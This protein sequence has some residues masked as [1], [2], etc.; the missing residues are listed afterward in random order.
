MTLPYLTTAFN[1]RE[2]DRIDTLRRAWFDRFPQGNPPPLGKPG[3]PYLLLLTL[4]GQGPA[5]PIPGGD[6]LFLKPD[7]VTRLF[8]TLL[9]SPILSKGIG[10]LDA[11]GSA[12]I[13]LDLSGIAP[14]PPQLYGRSL[15]I[16]GLLLSSSK[17][18]TTAPLR[19]SLIP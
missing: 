4:S 16:S 18:R 1:R 10:I 6:L 2:K 5:L 15:D 13:S 17:L 9:G 12:Q 3:P 11:K 14:L 7:G 19:I 8:L